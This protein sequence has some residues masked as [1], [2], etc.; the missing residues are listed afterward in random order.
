MT[1]ERLPKVGRYE[2]IWLE[3]LESLD[4]K[5][6]E[7]E[8]EAELQL[9]TE[10]YRYWRPLGLYFIILVFGTILLRVSGESQTETFVFAAILLSVPAVIVYLFWN[11]AYKK[12]S[13]RYLKNTNDSDDV[14]DTSVPQLSIENYDTVALDLSDKI[15]EE[16][17][18]SFRLEQ[19][20]GSIQS[21]EWVRLK[22][23]EASFLFFIAL[24]R[25]DQSNSKCLSVR[26]KEQSEWLI[27]ILSKFK[28][29]LPSH[30]ITELSG[31]T[32]KT[33]KSWV[34]GDK[35][36]KSKYISTIHE[37][38]STDAHITKPPRTQTGPLIIPCS[39]LTV[40]GGF[41]FVDNIRIIKDISSP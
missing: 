24:N 26:P 10:Y 30:L 13:L 8:P 21:T 38:L 14:A 19:S 39:Q 12:A 27:R 33:K 20:D 40:T 11:K 16:D 4:K 2:L 41:R 18:Y 6:D 37:A 34:D 1:P 9:E 15:I 28:S 5:R 17:S 23:K 35:N 29:G 31:A 7:G 25:Q 36:T 3:F 22:L 32:S